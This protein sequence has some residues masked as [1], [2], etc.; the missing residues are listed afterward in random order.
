[1]AVIHSKVTAKR[2]HQG[3][4]SR[5]NQNEQLTPPG[6]ESAA[7]LA[8]ETSLKYQIGDFF[9]EGGMAGS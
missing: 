4:K 8:V 6:V 3:G 2:A 5:A 1:M 9:F 7:I